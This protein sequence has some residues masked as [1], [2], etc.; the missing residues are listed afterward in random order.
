[1]E[2]DLHPALIRA[3]QIKA[4]YQRELTALNRNPYLDQQTR[5]EHAERLWLQASEQIARLRQTVQPEFE[6]FS[7]DE[8]SLFDAPKRPSYLDLIE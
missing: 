7:D 4:L 2:V 3:R 5:T 6:R 1:M 8:R